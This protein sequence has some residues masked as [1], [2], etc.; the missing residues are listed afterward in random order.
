MPTTLITGASSGLGAEM[1]RQLAARGW[2]LALAAR[3]TER[4]EELRDG[5]AAQPPRRPC[6]LRA[7]DGTD[8][9]HDGAQVRA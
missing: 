4:P 3:R 5:H 9:D 1:A 7:P 2:D 6:H 8:T